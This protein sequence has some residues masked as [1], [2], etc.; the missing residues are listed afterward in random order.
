MLS[1]G[2]KCIIRSR[3]RIYRLRKTATSRRRL[4]EAGSAFLRDAKY[5][6][7]YSERAM[8]KAKEIVENEEWESIRIGTSIIPVKFLLGVRTEGA[9]RR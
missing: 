2:G 7:G 5:L 8:E 9:G 1:S 3:L 6:V 4:S